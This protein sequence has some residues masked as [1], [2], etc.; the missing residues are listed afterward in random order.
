MKKNCFYCAPATEESNVLIN[1]NTYVPKILYEIDLEEIKELS[2]YIINNFKP[3]GAITDVEGYI[4]SY[5][6]YSSVNPETPYFDIFTKLMSGMSGNRFLFVNV[7]IALIEKCMNTDVDKEKY[8]EAYNNNKL[9][10][11]NQL[12]MSHM[13]YEPLVVNYESFIYSK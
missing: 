5:Y 11:N 9:L 3:I 12:K 6:S 13:T 10:Y 1:H 7:S 8:L 2:S 4:M